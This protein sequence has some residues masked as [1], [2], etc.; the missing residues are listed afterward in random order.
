MKAS[1]LLRVCCISI[2]WNV[3]MHSHLRVIRALEIKRDH[4]CWKFEAHIDYFSEQEGE[5]ISSIVDRD[6]KI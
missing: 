4:G 3:E 2:L 1:K 6:L 5:S